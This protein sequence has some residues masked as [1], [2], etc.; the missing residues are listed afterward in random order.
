MSDQTT[1]TT[2]TDKEKTVKK[3]AAR[4][5]VAPRIEEETAG[6]GN[7]KK[8]NTYI[9]GNPT[10]RVQERKAATIVSPA[11]VHSEPGRTRTPKVISAPVGVVIN[12]DRLP[13]AK[14][15]VNTGTR[16]VVTATG[17]PESPPK[18]RVPERNITPVSQ[19][20]SPMQYGSTEPR[21]QTRN[22]PSLKEA[23][24]NQN[25]TDK[26]NAPADRNT[27]GPKNSVPGQNKAVAPSNNISTVN[28][29]V[30]GN[31]TAIT[32]T[33]SMPRRLVKTVVTT[34][35]TTYEPV[36]EEE[37]KQ[38]EAQ[39]LSQG[40]GPITVQQGTGPI[41]TQQVTG[42]IV[43]TQAAGQNS[44]PAARQQGPVKIPAANGRPASPGVQQRTV[45]QTPN[46]AMQQRQV[47][48]RAVQPGQP[49]QRQP[50][51]SAGQA[52]QQP[53]GQT[54]QQPAPRQPAAPAKPMTAMDRQLAEIEKA[55]GL[56]ADTQTVQQ[57]IPG[58]PPPIAG[59][60]VV[61][62]GAAAGQPGSALPPGQG[63]PPAGD[64]MDAQTKKTM[65]YF[66]LGIE[67]LIFVIVLCVCVSI[68]QKIKNKDY[69]GGTE[70]AASYEESSSGQDEEDSDEG[71]TESF[72]VE[73]AGTD[74][75]LM[76]SDAGASDDGSELSDS[77]SEETPLSDSVDVENDRFSLHCTN[78]TVTLDTSGNPVALIF[79]TF[80]NR[81][82]NQLSLQEVFPIKVEQNGEAC[83]TSASL[84]E[85]PEEFYNKDMQISDGSSINCC[86]AVSLKDA[87][88]PLRLTVVDNYD[89]HA[90]IGATEIAIQ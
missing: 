25:A 77:V 4:S 41:I 23:L 31:Q 14:K 42:P 81:T 84:E 12:E 61:I 24:K 79:F 74:D 27:P 86:Y 15:Q 49:M 78:I 85:Y 75:E 28:K 68:Y 66:M 63:V 80:A 48:Q 29:T 16:P 56:S 33:G 3:R 62:P 35:T 43:T 5:I 38:L 71:G 64:Q 89:T 52:I 22:T 47:Q 69:A 21:N 30:T 13:P 1:K 40:T 76:P 54:A 67:A 17:W 72:N 2:T 51:Q 55:L 9:P 87:I 59:P 57:P 39:V 44:R 45:Q 11:S 70:E 50:Q 73:Q 7:S 19:N 90:D 32:D 26:R 53:V 6:S 10:P 18:P 60:P 88:S 8:T 83:E 58:A 20:T 65:E 37:L 34:T 82:G 36:T 46:A